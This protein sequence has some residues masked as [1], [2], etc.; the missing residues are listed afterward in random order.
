M[1]KEL[2][3]EALLEEIEYLNNAVDLWKQRCQDMAVADRIIHQ[4]TIKMAQYRI[5]QI[6]NKVVDLIENGIDDGEYIKIHKSVANSA[7]VHM[8]HEVNRVVPNSYK[9][10][11]GN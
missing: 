4:D 9:I 10:E 7:I 3:I 2:N 1:S 5:V 11:K 8:K 6:M